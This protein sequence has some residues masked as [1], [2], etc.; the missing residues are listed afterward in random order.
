MWDQDPFHATEAEADLTGWMDEIRATLRTEDRLRPEH[1][2]QWALPLVA[3]DRSSG[4][5]TFRDEAD[6]V[7]HVRNVV[8]LTPA[9]GAATFCDH[10]DELS[11]A[12]FVL[13]RASDADVDALRSC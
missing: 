3:A 11:L 10:G 13:L 8:S 12:Y 6:L 5:E 9:V 4:G 1:T 7:A 2:L